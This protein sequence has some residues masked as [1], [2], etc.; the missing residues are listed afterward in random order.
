MVVGTRGRRLGVVN[1]IPPFLPAP[2]DDGAS[3]LPDV[4][5]GLIGIDVIDGE[6]VPRISVRPHR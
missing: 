5:D 6:L 2:D 1:H 3:D 4:F